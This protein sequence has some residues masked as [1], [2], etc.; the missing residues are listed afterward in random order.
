MKQDLVKNLDSSKQG[1]SNHQKANEHY[2]KSQFLKENNKIEEAINEVSNSLK[3]NTQFNEAYTL[4]GELYLEKNQLKE[5]FNDFNKAI[6]LNQTASENYYFRGTIFWKQEKFEKSLEDCQKAIRLNPKYALA[7]NRIGTV[8]VDQGKQSDAMVQYTK[9]IEIDPKCEYAYMNRGLLFED[10]KQNDRALDDYNTAI[11]LNPERSVAYNNRGILLFYI[12]KF[13]EALMDY[14]QAIKINPLN[15]GVFNNRARLFSMI[16]Q[17]DNALKDLNKALEIN[18]EHPNSFN[19]RGQLFSEKEQYDLAIKDF[20]KAI[21]LNPQHALAYF[22]RAN[23]YEVTEQREK[24]LKDYNKAIELDPEYPSS[25]NNRGMLLKII[26]KSEEAL[27][28]YQ[29][30]IMLSS[31]NPLY[32]ANIGDI[33]YSNQSYHQA[34]QYYNQSLLLLQQ[35][36]LQLQTEL[37]LTNDNLSFIKGK[38]EILLLIQQDIN[39]I[40]S[41]LELLPGKFQKN[42]KVSIL[43]SE[44]I[45]NIEQQVIKK[46]NTSSSKEYQYQ[47]QNLLETLREMQLD[48]KIVRKEIIQLKQ[49]NVELRQ[50]IQQLEFQDRYI[51]DQ[52]MVEL[53]K[54]ENQHQFIYY[55]A[56]FWRLYYYLQAMAQISTDLYQFNKDA[57]IEST[58][59]NVMNIVQKVFNVGTSALGSVPIV[60]NTFMIIN[61][62]LDFTLEYK[63]ENKFKRR[64]IRLNNILRIFA[65]NPSDLEIEVQMAAIQLSKQQEKNFKQKQ[66][67]QFTEFVDQLAQKENQIY[68]SNFHWQNGTE[69]ALY[70]LK[71]LEENNSQILGEN[72]EQ[73]KLREILVEAVKQNQEDYIISSQNNQSKQVERVSSGC[74]PCLIY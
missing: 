55:K 49:E 39:K 58:S 45:N 41:D 28:D 59:E 42:K 65:I 43:Y 51:I 24:A 38:I 21:E 15:V 33:Y 71:Y 74:S 68:E 73:K 9:A 53:K 60:G 35:L 40:K 46:L 26:G 3:F 18:P 70:I 17:Q 50:K 32:F 12:G 5:A 61:A 13:Q 62:A 52:S 7:Y 20:N 11:K 66:K 67:S 1:I 10:L 19:N 2:K 22:N 48:L 54:Q 23:L 25:Y 56:L 37:N 64:L 6:E 63:K 47:Q 36:T 30:A 44:K 34:T 72:F 31:N 57:M 8:L 4:R 69:D 16:G 29:K 27:Q 14:D